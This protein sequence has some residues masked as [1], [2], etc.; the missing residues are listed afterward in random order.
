MSLIDFED[1]LFVLEILRNEIKVHHIHFVVHVILLENH[2]E[3][4]L[5]Y[6][7]MR[8]QNEVEIE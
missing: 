6:V 2:E 1:H 4:R 7:V 3:I 5:L 8:L